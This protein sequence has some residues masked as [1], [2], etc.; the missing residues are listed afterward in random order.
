VFEYFS[1]IKVDSHELVEMLFNVDARSN[2]DK[3]T[4]TLEKWI[5][6]FEPK[7]RKDFKNKD[8]GFT[9]SPNF[10]KFEISPTGVPGWF[11][12]VFEAGV[13]EYEYENIIDMDEARFSF[14]WDTIE[15]FYYN[16]DELD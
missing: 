16:G 4:A 3:I 15:R 11:D 9:V 2:E 13:Y 6:E 8:N 5:S 10:E 7:W 12:I 14:K 1:K